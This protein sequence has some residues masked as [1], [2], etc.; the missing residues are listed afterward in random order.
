MKGVAGFVAEVLRLGRSPD[1]QRCYVHA[2]RE[3]K[4]RRITGDEEL[5]IRKLVRKLFKC[6]LPGNID[7][8][9][10]VERVGE[11]LNILAFIGT[12]CEVEG[13]MRIGC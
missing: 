3:V 6:P 10:R 1:C 12:A 13:L 4:R 8:S 2:R 9:F 5:T 11:R 7:D